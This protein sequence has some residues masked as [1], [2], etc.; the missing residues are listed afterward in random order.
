[1]KLHDEMMDDV[2]SYAL[3]V[4]PADGVSAL[5]G[6]LRACAVCSAEYR[7]LSAAVSAVAY[8][9][10]ACATGE[11]GPKVSPMLKERVMSAVRARSDS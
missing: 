6:H 9:A 4:L 3:G 10:Q 1:M 7:R 5:A 8:A 2:A 11:N